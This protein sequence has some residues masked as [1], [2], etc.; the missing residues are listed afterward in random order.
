MQN[1]SRILLLLLIGIAFSC[2]T[3][4]PEPPQELVQDYSIEQEVSELIIPIEI[5]IKTLEQQ[6]NSYLKGLVYEDNNLSDDNIAVKIWKKSDIQIKASGNYIYYKV[7]LK[8]WLKTALKIE[9]LGIDLGTTKET[10][11]SVSLNF[12]SRVNIDENW[13][14]E[15]HTVPDGYE[16][17]QK[18][19]VSMSGFS[20]PVTSIADRILKSEFKSFAK[21]IDDQARPYLEIK[22]TVEVLWSRMHDPVLVS[23]DPEVWLKIQP[24]ELSVSPLKGNEE[25]IST[26]VGIKCKASTRLGAKPVT[27]L[28]KLPALAVH[29]YRGG[30]FNVSVMGS[31]T[32]EKATEMASKEL[33]GE[34]FTFGKNGKKYIEVKNIEI[35]PGGERLITKLDVSGSISGTIYLSGIPSFDSETEMLFLNDFDF[36]LDTKNKLLKSANWLAHGAFAKKIAPYFEYDLGPK[37][38]ESRKAV[39]EAIENR[40]VYDKIKLTGRLDKLEPTK[41]FLSRNSIN[42]VVT[43]NGKLE[44]E[45]NKF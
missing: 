13:K 24:M 25:K 15:T 12:R 38:S 36:D 45:V 3:I 5:P 6:A 32:Y 37:L 42:A 30:Y 8:V 35:Y 27:N 23:D 26:L 18:P 14:I 19:S 10:E 43:G 17:I 31:L 40:Q 11:F 2:K 21:M 33:L 22:E 16:W 9:S 4:S 7:P 29:N 39:K 20:V 28:T 1:A 34:K 44:V 41:I